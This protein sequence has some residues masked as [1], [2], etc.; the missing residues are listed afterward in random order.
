MVYVTQRGT[1]ICPNELFFKF[2]YFTERKEALE[3]F[4]PTEYEA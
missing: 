4:D 2:A 3:G 1:G